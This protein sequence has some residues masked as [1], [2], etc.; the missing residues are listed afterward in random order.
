[1]RQ[2]FPHLF[3][4]IFPSGLF[5]TPKERIRVETWSGA[6]WGKPLKPWASS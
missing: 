3:N 1:V 5:D 2:F 4:L 6:C